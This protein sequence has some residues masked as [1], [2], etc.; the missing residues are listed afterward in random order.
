MSVCKSTSQLRLTQ[1][2]SEIPGR[3]P[4]VKA[5]GYTKAVDLWSLGCVTT[6]MLTGATPFSSFRDPEDRRTSYEVIIEAAVSCD[7]SRLDLLSQWRSASPDAKD[8]VERLLVLDETAR[9]TASE[10]LRHKWYEDL[11]RDF[12][13][14]YKFSLKNYRPH[15]LVSNIVER[16]D[17]K[18][19]AKKATKQVSY[20]LK[21]SNEVAILALT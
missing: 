8:F 3:N 2:I 20:V 21:R 17:P 11:R 16:I 1:N 9:M 14:V 19:A 15:A 6:A 18:A 5:K 10:G 7:L 4:A 12:D 13:E